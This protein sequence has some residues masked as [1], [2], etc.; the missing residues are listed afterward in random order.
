M[1]KE[2]TPRSDESQE[3]PPEKR[4]RKPPQPAVERV[5]NGLPIDLLCRA[6]EVAEYMGVDDETWKLWTDAGLETYQPGTRAPWVFTADVHAFVR[7]CPA[8][9]VRKSAVRK[10]KANE[11]K[12]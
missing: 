3:V 5:L 8:L 10:Q 1:D 6:R 2:N 7:K 4:K 11:R 12:K 9:G